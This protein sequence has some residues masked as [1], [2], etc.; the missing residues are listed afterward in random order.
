MPTLWRA[1]AVALV[2]TG[3]IILVMSFRP[4]LP[5]ALLASTTCMA[6]LCVP[7]TQQLIASHVR[8]WQ[9]PAL[10]I[11]VVR[12]VLMV[13]IY[14]IDSWL[15]LMNGVIGSSPGAWRRFACS[16]SGE[17]RSCGLADGVRELYGAFVIHSFVCYLV[18]SFG[19][20]E[21]L[22]NILRD[23]HQ[24]HH[25]WPL[26]HI[27]PRWKMGPSFLLRC[28]R[29]ALQY[30]VIRLVV[31]VLDVALNLQASLRDSPAGSLVGDILLLLSN[32][33]QCWAMYSL[34][35][36]YFAMRKELTPLR[37][38]AKFACI[39]FVVFVTFWQVRIYAPA[40]VAIC[41]SATCIEHPHLHSCS[42]SIADFGHR[43]SVESRFAR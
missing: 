25:V 37:P 10:Q 43:A 22:G 38:L 30:V 3:I 35:I 23:K 29:G 12:I 19:T 26:V 18:R 34:V 20:E 21:Q 16:A 32:C 1:I 42:C 6:A 39:K 8:H 33:S 14:A 41:S 15:A 24:V 31:T 36:F 11:C 28:K 2:Q 13:P 5:D 17:W 40:P 7:N 9:W 4:S 27:L